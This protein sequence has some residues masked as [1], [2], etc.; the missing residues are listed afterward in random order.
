MKDVTVHSVL[1]TQCANKL[2]L[3]LPIFVKLFACLFNVSDSLVQ[4]LVD[5]SQ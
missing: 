3:T 1:L 4:L 5:D 2:P